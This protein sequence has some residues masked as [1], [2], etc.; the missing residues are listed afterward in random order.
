MRYRGMFGRA[1]LSAAGDELGEPLE[2]IIRVVGTGRSLRMVLDR[3][4]R[5]AA[6]TESLARAVVEID[7]SRH[8][9]RAFYRC[10][11]HREA[12]IL[13]RDL[14]L[15]GREIPHRVVRAVMAKGQLVRLAA[16]GQ[17]ED[18]VAEA[19]AEDR[20]PSQQGAHRVGEIGHRLRVARAVREKHAVWL[21]LEH[22]VGR[23]RRRYDG[24]VTAD[25]GELAQD[26]EL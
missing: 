2:Q 6:V 9:S 22:G 25:G 5:Q 1:S 8:P 26:V 23:R 17:A 7:V 16:R 20:Q 21:E 15:T 24:D 18:L 19:N 13:R 11:I 12:V 10:R 14:D 3:K 4:R